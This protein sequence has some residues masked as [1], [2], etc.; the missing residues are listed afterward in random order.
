MWSSLFGGK[1]TEATNNLELKEQVR[2]WQRRLRSEQRRIERDIRRLEQEETKVRFEIKKSAARG[3]QKSCQIL[4]VEVLRSRK[5]KQRMLECCA[6]MNS[7]SMSLAQNLAT[8]NMSH[9][10]K[11]SSDVMHNMSELLKAPEVAATMGEL[12]K[13]MAKMGLMEEMMQEAIDATD[14]DD[15]CLGVD[16]EAREAVNRVMEELAINITNQLPSTGSSRLQTA[17]LVQP[18]QQLPQ[19][20]HEEPDVLQI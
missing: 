15:C 14:F 16:E 8:V 9:N 5:A 13:E 7:I 18:T 20:Q 3:D 1:R 11:S 17:D 19:R 2:T 6:R 12:S 10:I 4:C